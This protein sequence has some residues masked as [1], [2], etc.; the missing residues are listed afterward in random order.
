[1][2]TGLSNVARR[3]TKIIL[4]LASLP[5]L[6]TFAGCSSG[7]SSNDRQAGIEGTGIVSGFGSVYI[8]GM[9]FETDDA[10][11]LFVGDEVPESKLSVGDRVA[12]TGTLDAD[13]GAHAERIVY[14]RTL[15]GPIERIETDG[16]RGS[17]VAL[18]QTV[19][20]DGD[21]TFVTTPAD[22]LAA[23]DLIAVS[24]FTRPSNRV[25]AESIRQSE[26]DFV[27]NNS[28]L[29][30]EGPIDTIDD[31]RL[32]VG[33]QVIDFANADVRPGRAALT[34]GS[35]I[36]AFGTRDASRNDPLIASRINVQSLNEAP[37]GRQMLVGAEI[38]DYENLSDF[39]AGGWRIDARDAERQGDDTTALAPG[40]RVSVRG[41]FKNGRVRARTLW[42]EP[43]ANG[44]LQAPA[45]AIDSN[46][47]TLTLFG[48]TIH[49]SAQTGYTDNSATNDRTLRMSTLS[50]GDTL[51]VPLY[52]DHGKTVARRIVRVPDS[53]AD[54]AA[55]AG[56]VT[57]TTRNGAN[58]TL[59]VA[60]VNTQLADDTTTYYDADG[61]T[62]DAQTFFTRVDA[63]ARVR[64]VGPQNGAQISV[65]RS[66]RILLDQTN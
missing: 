58:A 7:G 21:T 5:V 29:E 6:A 10:T 47:D 9:E 38:D 12:V 62:I 36:E 59:V 30:I 56:H 43:R 24:G 50:P 15:D 27:P 48:R 35:R 34:S 63:G 14:L 32:T 54:D 11:I 25:Y 16:E 55:V 45:D 17:L 2:T 22:E 39:V 44:M 61:T 66:A 46:A 42:V 3:A 40:V 51:R 19:Y 64:L 60:G 52:M 49:V 65:V 41:V 23:G 4:L 31:T 37:E 13:G 20:F 53:E 26:T 1:M 28:T 33:D 18:G 8:E 57:D